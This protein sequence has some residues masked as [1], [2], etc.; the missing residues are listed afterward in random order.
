[1]IYGKMW[2]VVR[3]QVGIPLFLSAV[4]ISSFAVHLALVTNTPWLKAYYN[5][6]ANRT[7]P[8]A[9]AAPAAAPAEAPK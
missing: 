8:A 2:T 6:A 7:A 4:A 1:M 9:V 3:P 5:G